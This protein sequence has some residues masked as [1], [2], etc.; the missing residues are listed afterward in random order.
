MSGDWTVTDISPISP[1]P[2]DSSDSDDCVSRESVKKNSSLLWNQQSAKLKWLSVTWPMKAYEGK[3]PMNERKAEWYRFRDQFERIASGKPDVDPM[4]KLTALKI[5]GGDH[6]LSIIEMQEKSIKEPCSDIFA[7]VKEALN[8]YFNKM[9][10][11]SKERMKFREMEMGADEVFEDWILRLENQAKFC[12]FTDGQRDEEFLQA[13]SRRSIPEISLE[14]YKV[15]EIFKRNVEKLITHGQHLDY[16]RREMREKENKKGCDGELVADGTSETKPINA[17]RHFERNNYR[18]RG[19]RPW[20]GFKE[21]Q[22][23]RMSQSYMSRPRKECTKCGIIHGPR[24]CRAFGKKCH[25]CDMIGHFAQ[26]CR[27][28]KSRRSAPKEDEDSK[29]NVKN[30]VN[31]I[32]KV[33]FSD[34][35]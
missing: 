5:Q 3:L 34:S 11:P 28:P 19:E 6:L 33:L 22:N 9:C 15:S 2:E 17:V 18:N 13:I 27:N 35:E 7:R 14:L 8:N 21:R 10:D 25:N 12:E 23:N 1:C 24:N 30:E 32:N 29:K 26:F 16:M 4:T 20:N 31:Q